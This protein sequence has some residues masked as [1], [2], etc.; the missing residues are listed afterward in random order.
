MILFT[1]ERL[2][3]GNHSVCVLDAF[4]GSGEPAWTFQRMLESIVNRLMFP[5]L[6]E[7]CI[8]IFGICGLRCQIAKEK[9]AA[10][11]IKAADPLTLK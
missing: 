6:R 2:S 9:R 8:L 1:S 3:V 7:N 5:T 10:E 4:E 11:G